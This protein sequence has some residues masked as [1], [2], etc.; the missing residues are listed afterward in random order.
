MYPCGRI[1]LKGVEKPPLISPEKSVPSEPSCQQAGEESLPQV[2]PQ[3]E[4]DR[5]PQRKSPGLSVLQPNTTANRSRF[6][7]DATNATCCP[8]SGDAKLV[9]KTRER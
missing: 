8:G 3:Q 6:F 7:E 5:N 9:P 1:T 2:H 4:S